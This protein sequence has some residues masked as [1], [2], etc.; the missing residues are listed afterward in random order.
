MNSKYV[1]F[2][3]LFLYMIS[4]FYA[5][6]NTSTKSADKI[7]SADSIPNANKYPAEII[8]KHLEKKYDNAAWLYY[9]LNYTKGISCLY[10][11][12]GKRNH[13]EDTMKLASFDLN[14]VPIKAEGVTTK[15]EDDTIEILFFLRHAL[16]T[17]NCTYKKS[18]L[19]DCYG[20]SKGSD[21]PTYAYPYGFKTKHEYFNPI[22]D[23][24][25]TSD[26]LFRLYVKQ[27]RKELSSTVLRL[28]KT[29]NEF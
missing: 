20:F 10:F 14:G 18:I 28:S 26:S 3:G 1:K 23:K 5:C 17:C 19:I 4:G 25:K 21:I 8:Q 7:I 24:I 29:K 15:T 11:K 27:H 6:K 2:S 22:K 9:I 12:N 13:T 16:D